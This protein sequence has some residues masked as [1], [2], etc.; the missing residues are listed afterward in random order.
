MLMRKTKNETQIY[1]KVNLTK[2]I[3]VC[4]SFTP[5]VKLHSLYSENKHLICFVKLILIFQIQALKAPT[6]IDRTM[7]CP[8]NHLGLTLAYIF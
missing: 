4:R 2:A 5:I 7:L 3:M 1:L 8:I 6:H